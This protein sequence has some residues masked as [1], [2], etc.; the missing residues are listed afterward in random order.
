MKEPETEKAVKELVK[1]W[2]REHRAWSYA[3]IQNGLGEHGIHDRIGCVPVVVTEEMVGK[4]IGLFVS[5]E[6]KAPGRRGEPRRGMSA[7]QQLKLE[8]I[9]KAGGISICCDGAQDLNLLSLEIVELMGVLDRM[10][11]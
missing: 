1:D 5:V 8:E 11:V 2:Y 10:P 6:A 4:Q 9:R 7:H 3:P